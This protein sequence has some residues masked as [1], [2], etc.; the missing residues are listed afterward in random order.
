MIAGIG[1]TGIGI[2]ETVLFI[3]PDVTDSTDETEMEVPTWALGIGTETL[4]VAILTR[5]VAPPG[6][7]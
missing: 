4:P 1:D 2:E 3:H 7:L 5:C 6:K